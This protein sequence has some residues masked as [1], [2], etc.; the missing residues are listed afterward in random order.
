MRYLAY[1]FAL[2]FAVLSIHAGVPVGR[3]GQTSAT[4]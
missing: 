3:A 2:G 4:G 1:A